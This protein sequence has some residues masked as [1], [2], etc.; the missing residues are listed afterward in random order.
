MR[1]R[2]KLILWYSGLLAIIIVIFGVSVYRVMDMTLV[3]SVD[4]TLDQTADL[5]I[6][7]SRIGRFGL[8]G[9]PDETVIQL[10]PLDLFRASSVGVQV[11]DVRQEDDVHLAAASNN[12]GGYIDPFNPDTVGTEAPTFANVIINEHEFR[13]LTRPVFA[14]SQVFATV[15]VAAPL[16]TVNQAR[17]RLVLVLIVSASVGILGSVALGMWLSN[18]AL[19]PIE[20]ITA[21][22]SKIAQT[23]DLTTRLPWH[24]PMD[25]L[26]NLTSVFNHM[27]DR[28]EDLFSLQRRFVADVSHELRTPLT[29]IR[30]NL[31]LVKRYGMDDMSLEAIESEAERMSRMVDDLLMLARADYGGLT[32]ELEPL[33]LDTVVMEAYRQGQMLVSDR[34]LKVDLTGLEPVRVA[35]NPDRIKQVI[36]NLLGNAIKFTPDGGHIT[37]GLS[38]TDDKALIQVKD[39]GI[40]I[41]EDDQK[42]IFDRFYQADASRMRA[43]DSSSGLGLAIAKWI[44]EAHDGVI[45]VESELDKGS[46]F[47]VEIPL[48]KTTSHHKDEP[49][50]QHQRLYQRLNPLKL[51]ESHRSTINRLD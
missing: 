10:P 14:L 33:D 48:L 16:D 30:G 12:L 51:G 15:Q 25:E 44:V 47:V 3:D 46:T 24:G 40:G 11:W 31:D 36:L 29:A 5:V 39:T 21:A 17:D 49:D 42:H 22:A 35:G 7:N 50:K 13:V 27:M 4:D 23:D 28:L 37:V 9:G 34:D 2:T 43:E 26:G 41:S 20:R 38:A 18:R 8:F 32:L 6:R 45:N 1:I 19:K